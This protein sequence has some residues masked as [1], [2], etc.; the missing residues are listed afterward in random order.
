MKNLNASKRAGV[1]VLVMLIGVAAGAHA[2]GLTRTFDAKEMVKI[3]T[4][5]GDCIIRKGEPGKIIVEVDAHYTPYDSFEPKIRERAN[6][7]VIDEK[8][9]G[10]SS[11]DSDWIITVPDG[12]RIRFSSASG[13]FEAHDLKGDFTVSVASG[14]ILLTN[15]EGE[16]DLSSASG[17]VV[18]EDCR[19]DFSASSASGRVEGEG[20]TLTQS[21]SF[22]AASGDVDLR[23]AASPDWGLA[24]SS[25]SGKALLNFGG[26]P[27]KGYF[28]FVAKEG[29]GRI[30]SPIDFDG[31]EV[32]RRHGDRYIAKAFTRG[33]DKPEILIETASG[34][35]EL[36][37]K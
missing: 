12:T 15:C 28:E 14:E 17:D 7:I 36:R 32:F 20:V 3:N 25:A 8:F 23:L 5:S 4:I 27:I 24:V 1:I 18:L 33:E 19:G 2:R 6:S 34:K 31:E 21:S 30:I 26:N 9:Y 29:K 22:S 37:E 10:S 13:D 35:A 16:F 11:G